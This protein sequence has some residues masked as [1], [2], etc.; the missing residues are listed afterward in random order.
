MA[1]KKICGIY[2]MYHPVSKHYYIGSSAD[3][4]ARWASHRS[5]NKYNTNIGL[6]PAITAQYGNEWEFE[7]LEE[8]DSDVLEERE[9]EYLYDGKT[10]CMCINLDYRRCKA[11]VRGVKR[12]K[13]DKKNKALSMLGKNGVEGKRPV[14][15]MS[16]T[17]EVYRNVFSVSDFCQ[18]HNLPQPMMNAVANGTLRMSKG[19]TL[20]STEREVYR[21]RTPEGELVEVL[22]GAEWT[23]PVS[24]ATLKLRATNKYQIRHGDDITEDGRAYHLEG[25]NTLHTIRYGDIELKNVVSLAKVAETY[26]IPVDALTRARK[27]AVEGRRGKKALVK[28]V[29]QEGWIEGT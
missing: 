26:N 21:V 11:S 27:S 15:F 19:W 3:M 22:E 7:V 29:I 18:E 6:I 13:K 9:L 5:K 8:C 4:K 10:D 28:V 16:P 12:T 17:G 25:E 23:L 14:S 2:S 20:A 24:L 1:E